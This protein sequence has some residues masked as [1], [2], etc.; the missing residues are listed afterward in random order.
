MNYSNN[1]YLLFFPPSFT[2]SLI[3]SF[4]HLLNSGGS[5][6]YHI[7]RNQLS[8]PKLLDCL[9]AVTLLLI[10]VGFLT[11]TSHTLLLTKG[12]PLFFTLIRIEL[13]LTRK[14]H[15]VSPHGVHISRDL[16]IIKLNM[17]LILV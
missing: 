16:T 17:Y 4:T 15:L 1:L 13:I 14:H 11:A 7:Q 8:L 10:Q 2:H 6:C 5:Q 9:Y 12:Q 3:H